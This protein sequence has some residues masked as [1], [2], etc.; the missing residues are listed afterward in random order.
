MKSRAESSSLGATRGPS[1]IA[2]GAYEIAEKDIAAR[3][4]EIAVA[5][6][7][8]E[9]SAARDSAAIVVRVAAIVGHADQDAHSEMARWWIAR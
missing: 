3:N 7:A 8:T 5:A 2:A 4:L 6:Q 1:R 9:V